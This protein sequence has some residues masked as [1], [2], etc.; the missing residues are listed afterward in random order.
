MPSID[1]S[2]FE[3]ASVVSVLML[4]AYMVITEKLVWHTRLSRAEARADRWETV[5]LEALSAGAQAGVRAAE[6][7][8]DVVQALPDPQGVRERAQG[9]EAVSEVN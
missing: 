4:V 2:M 1:L 6:V 7:A 5:A 8:V 9:S 3:G